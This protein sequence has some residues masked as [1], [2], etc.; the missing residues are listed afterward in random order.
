VLVEFAL[1]IS[2]HIAQAADTGLNYGESLRLTAS[3]RQ[4]GTGGVALEDPLRQGWIIEANTVLVTP[5][6]RWVGFG[7]QGGWGPDLRIGAEGLFLSSQGMTKTLENSDGTLGGE[8]NNTIDYSEWGGRVLGQLTVLD[9]G[10]WR[11]ALLCRGV[12]LFQ[13]LPDTRNS[14]FGFDVGMQMQTDLPEHRILTIWGLAGPVGLG[15]GYGFAGKAAIGAGLLVNRPHGFLGVADGYMIGADGDLLWEGLFDGGLGVVY[16][17]GRLGDAGTTLFLRGGAR[18]VS[19]GIRQIDPRYGLGLLWRGR[20]KYG[21]Q[22]DY[23]LVP[24]GEMGY[25]HYVSM[26]IRFP[27]ASSQPATKLVPE[28]TLIQPAVTSVTAMESPRQEEEIRYFSPSLGEKVLFTVVMKKEGILAADLSDQNGNPVRNIQEPHTVQHGSHQV[29]WDG[30][31]SPG[32]YVRYDIP[33][34]LRITAGE[35]TRY[36]TV[37]ARRPF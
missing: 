14:G 19:G 11:A 12:L 17:L 8:S 26:G 1:A 23:S 36:V 13:D 29:E 4:A 6:L 32:V 16:Y 28:Q 37:V 15:N 31:L 35:E 10:A 18:L 27:Q 9:G 33:Y 25:L 2:M 3:A 7:C 30:I 24:R 21:F 22:F 20:A 34:I 5:H